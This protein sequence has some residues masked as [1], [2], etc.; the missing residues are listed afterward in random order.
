MELRMCQEMEQAME[1]GMEPGMELGWIQGW[2]RGR[3][4][5]WSWDG[6]GDGAGGELGMEHF[7]PGQRGHT[8]TG[9]RVL[10]TWPRRQIEASKAGHVPFC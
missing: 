8:S 9:G 1:L 2:S 3:S 10:K 4:W 6:A 7:P 5:K